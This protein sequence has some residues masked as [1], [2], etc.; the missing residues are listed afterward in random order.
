MGSDF[1]RHI[2]RCCTESSKWGRYDAE[3]LPMWVADTDF[4]SPEPVIRALLDRVE[5]GIFGY[6]TEPPVLRPLVVERLKRQHNWD[7]TPDALIFSPGVIV[8]FNQACHGLTQPGDGLLIQVP[9]YP[10]I[11]SA[12][13][14]SRLKS[15]QMELTRQGDGR[16]VVD[17]DLMEDTIDE[18]T[19]AFLLCNPHNPVGRAFTRSELEGM[20]EV[21]LRHDMVIISDEIHCDLLLDGNVHTPIASLSPEVGSRTVTL[22]SPSK[23]FNIAGLKCSVAIV[24]DPELRKRFVAG[25]QG[26]VSS[27]NLMG[28]VAA[29]AAYRDGQKWLDQLLVY[30]TANRDHTKRYVDE[31]LPGIEMWPSEGTFLAWLDCRQAGI[32]GNAHQFFLKQAK[33]VMNDGAAFGRGGEGHVRLNFGCCRDLLDQALSR[34]RT[35]LEAL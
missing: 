7:V 28:W 20:A 13:G 24:P 19:R 23:T 32:E 10:P 29:V 22:I 34:M 17:L 21:C 11:I 5:H 15:Q 8:G 1:D 2:D 25:A 35:A 26:L 4:M 18:S 30:L 16:Y 31:Y 9:V 3:A 6:P 14:N 12:A 27:V 33:V